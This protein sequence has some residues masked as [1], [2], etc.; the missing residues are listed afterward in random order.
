MLFQNKKISYLFTPIWYLDH[1]VNIFSRFIMPTNVPQKQACMVQ[2]FWS[3]S[4]TLLFYSGI[5]LKNSF[6]I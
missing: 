4:F 3:S 1:S 2:N 6:S 5:W